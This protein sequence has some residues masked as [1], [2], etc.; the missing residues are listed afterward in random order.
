MTSQ[1][2][3]SETK[4]VCYVFKAMSEAWKNWTFD[5]AHDYL[6]L[7][8]IWIWLG[9]F[10]FDYL[11]WL[12][13]ITSKDSATTWPIVHNI[14]MCLSN[15]V[16]DSGNFNPL[17]GS[18][19]VRITRYIS[20]YWIY[21]AEWH[22]YTEPV[23][24]AKVKSIS[25]LKICRNLWTWLLKGIFAN[26]IHIYMPVATFLSV[27]IPK[28]E[29]SFTII[30]SW[31]LMVSLYKWRV[32]KLAEGQIRSVTC[33]STVWALRL[34]FTFVNDWKTNQ[35]N[36][37]S[38]HVKIIWNSNLGVYEVGSRSFVVSVWLRSGSMVQL[39]ISEGLQSRKYL[40]CGS[41]QKKF[42]TPRHRHS[43]F[44]KKSWGT[45]WNVQAEK[46]YHNE[47]AWNVNQ[48]A[49]VV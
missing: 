7:T 19:V 2:A 35:K 46:I 11:G 32:N 44:Q 30:I 26:L 31:T 47:L 21:C 13:P 40:L 43:Y 48:T 49:L 39:G 41:L 28:G 16:K 8:E 27:F 36:T 10:W 22:A 23:S 45:A 25:S 37:I 18:S 24:L 9:H 17:L 34:M 3:V 15:S 1:S 38:W 20:V 6:K 14:G 5:F 12:P 4:T 29:K 42:A 33:F